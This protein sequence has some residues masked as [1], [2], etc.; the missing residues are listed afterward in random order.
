MLDVQEQSVRILELE[1]VRVSEACALLIMQGMSSISAFGALNY[2]EQLYLPI[3]ADGFCSYEVPV[4]FTRVIAGIPS[5]EPIPLEEL[6]A[7]LATR[8]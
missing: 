5:K 4:R 3:I 1:D 8:T 6:V 2:D 7:A